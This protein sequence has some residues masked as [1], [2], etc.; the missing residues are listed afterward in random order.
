MLKPYNACTGSGMHHTTTPTYLV[1]VH[2]ANWIEYCRSAVYAEAVTI[3]SNQQTDYDSKLSSFEDSALDMHAKCTQTLSLR[4]FAPVTVG[5][6]I[7]I[8]FPEIKHSKEAEYV[9]AAL[10]K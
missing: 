8:I 7:I 9:C 1:K 4:F 6:M 3:R 2:C 5:P 10:S